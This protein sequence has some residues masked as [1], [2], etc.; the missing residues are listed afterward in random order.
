M[1]VISYLRGAAAGR[2]ATP[3]ADDAP[4]PTTALASV[5]DS[6]GAAINPDSYAHVY[7]YNGDGTPNTDT[8]TDGTYTCTL[9]YTWAGGLLTN[10]SRWV[11]S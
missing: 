8:F 10:A 5:R 6:T 3:V 11:R 4:L 7:T 2:P 1:N 9:T